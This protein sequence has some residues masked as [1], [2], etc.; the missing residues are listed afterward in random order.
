M[1]FKILKQEKNPFLQREE[2]QI[3]IESETNPCFEDVQKFLKK[4]EKVTVIK[5]IIGNSGRSIFVSEV[6]VYDS[7]EDKKKVE[8]ISQKTRKKLA[9]EAKKAKE[10]EEKAK[11]EAKKEAEKPVEEAPKEEVKEEKPSEENKPADK[12]VKE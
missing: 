8:T 9:E 12:E 1:K 3:E 4:D 10:A 5:K 6:F 11:E 2:Y 7:E